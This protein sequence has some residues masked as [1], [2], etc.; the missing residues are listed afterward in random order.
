MF[1]IG[2]V[3]IEWDPRHLYREL[4]VGRPDA[5]EWFL[6]HI[7]TAAWNLEQD[8]GR[9]WA[10]GVGV[11]VAERPE[12]R[13]EIEAFDRRWHDMIPRIIE[14]TVAI[15][16]AL[17]Q[18]GVPLYAITNFSSEKFAESTVR[19]PFF[20]WFD[21]TIVSGDEQLLKPSTRI[22]ELL[23]T[24]YG[25][26][27]AHCVFIDDVPDNVAAATTAGMVGIHF[28]SPATLKADLVECGFVFGD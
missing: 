10:D 6:E 3:L 11:L 24:R 15:L 25:L 27:A 28:T 12:W 19:F 17:R 16:G 26:E 13:S 23:C 18:A 14:G 4:F 20:A 22:F 5:M 21:G 9:T 1:D 7:C 2:N 8:R